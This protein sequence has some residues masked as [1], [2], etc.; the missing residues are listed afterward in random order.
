[1]AATGVAVALPIRAHWHTV[2]FFGKIRIMYKCPVFARRTSLDTTPVTGSFLF[3]ATGCRLAD[4][5]AG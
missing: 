2:T 1:M 5:S 3:D 4:F